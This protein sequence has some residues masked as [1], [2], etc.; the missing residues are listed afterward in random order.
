MYTRSSNL[1]APQ[2]NDRPR[3][4]GPPESK[5]AFT[6][7]EVVVTLGVL[8]IAL[9]GIAAVNSGTFALVRSAKQSSAASL[10]LQERVEQLRISNWRQITDA[11]YLKDTFFGRS[12]R[13]MAAI[14]T[15]TET[16][17][18]SS[19]PDA[20]TTEPVKVQRTSTGVRILTSG[21]EISNEPL[22]RVDIRIEWPGNNGRLRMRE[23]ST[24]ISKGGVARLNLGYPESSDPS[25]TDSGGGSGNSG[26][27]SND[28]RGNVGGKSGSK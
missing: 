27:N 13:N 28:N 25:S 12:I 22:A 15:A 9:A 23:T 3:F 14:P 7:V 24:I 6:L 20:S 16:I 1:I 18:I 2:R 26:G 8:L 10:S 21:S 19:Y 11:Q 4:S 5:D 17:T